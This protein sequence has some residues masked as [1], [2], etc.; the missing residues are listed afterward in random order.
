MTIEQLQSLQPALGQWLEKFRVCFKRAPSFSHLVFYLLGLLAELKRKSIEPIALAAGVAVRTLQEFLSYYEWD[1]Q[2]VGR[3]LMNDVA[4]RCPQGGIGVLDASGHPKRGDQT[5]GVG[6]QYCGETGKLDNCVVGQHLLFTDN[7]PRNPFTCMLDSDLYIP[8]D[9]LMDRDRCQKAGIPDTLGFRTKQEIAAEQVK[10]ALAA[11]VRLNWVVFDEDYGKD[12]QF[13][14]K[15]DAMGQ[16][17]VGE[18][19]KNFHVWARRPACRS[20]QAA[21][22]S[23]RVDNLAIFSPVFRDQD[24]KRCRVKDTTRGPLYWK[25]K[26]ARVHLVDHQGRPHHPGM[27]TDRM[28]W[29]LI[30]WQPQTDEYKYVISNAGEHVDLEQIIRV[31][32]SRWHIEKW[33]ER[34]KQETGLGAF[35]V[36]TYRSLI[37]HWLCVRL[38][39][40]F[41]AE[42]T[43]RLRGEKC[44]DHLRAGNGSGVVAGREDMEA[45]LAQLPGVPGALP[46]LP[47]S[48]CCVI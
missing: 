7:D 6:H 31:L 33:F 17:A 9:W 20:A 24:W 35:E 22:A 3:I 10:Q 5:P 47:V 8:K 23:S 11:G 25:Y 27:P 12:P 42:Q 41:L 45:E 4:N 28:Y 13:W 32:M 19:P 34:A 44:A 26:A 46:L 43:T 14:F 48:Q 30:L 2:R 21:H 16:L 1:H 40:C 29:L 18:V 39:M 36:R 38:A 37:R 15:L